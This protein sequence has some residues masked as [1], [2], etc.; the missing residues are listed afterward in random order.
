[1][2]G[3][4]KRTWAE[5]NLDR[6]AWNY[7]QIRSAVKP[8]VKVC[9][10]IKANGYG[11]NAVRLAALY[12]TLGADFLAVSNLEEALQLRQGQITLP[13]LILGYTPPECAGVLAKQNISQCVYSRTYGESLSQ[14]A[15]SDGVRV[16]IHIK[17]DSGMGRI[18]FQHRN[19][20]S[21]LADALAVCHLPC[22]KTE[23]IFTHFAV[24]DEADDGAEFTRTQY[25]NFL[26]AIRMLNENGIR[27]DIRHCANSAAIFDKPEL[28]EGYPDVHLDMVRAGVVL[29]GL[30]PS[31]V[32][33]NLPELR[34]VMALK[35]VISHIKTVQPGDSVSYGR[36]FISDSVRRIA[37][38]PIG[39][40][41]GFWRSNS[42]GGCKMLI[43]DRLFPLVGRVCMDQLMLDITGADDLN[44]GDIVTV[45]GDEKGLTSA[46]LIAEHTGTINYEVV[47]A[48]G[49][50]VPRFFL[51]EGVPVDVSDSIWKR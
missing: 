13:I 51:E 31:G 16:K 45:F 5:I 19:G 33:R 9:C 35:S 49:E 27:F 28:G 37:T 29:Y 14:A 50:R 18:G 48:V 47:C 21:E 25:R 41:D 36:T 38:V 2:Q 32:T 3:I 40:A 42:Q 12:E 6:A 10:V 26:D 4:R 30:K 23:G 11:H 22:L 7:R 39:Y 1:M 46:D 20:H 43:R 34:P 24:A 17:I 44:V 15:M 8:E